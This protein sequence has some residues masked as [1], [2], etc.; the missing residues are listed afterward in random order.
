M[1]VQSVKANINGQNYNLTY[2][3]TSGKWE[4]TITAPSVTSWHE[5]NNKYGITVTA[6]DDAGN[7]TVKDRTDSTLG[8]ALQLRVLEKVKPTVSLTSPSSGARVITATPQIKFSLRDSD[9]GIKI[10]SLQL[11]I[12]GGSAIGHDASGMICT[13]VSGGYDCVYV[14]PTALSEGA[15]TITIQVSDNDGNTSDLLSSGFTVD[16]VPPALNITNPA[17]GLITNKS[18]LTVSGTTN[19]ETSSPVTITIKLNGVDQGAVTVTNGNFSKAITLTEG[20]NII[21]VKAVDSAGLS[22]TVTRTVKLDT[23]PPVITAVTVTPNPVDA[24]KTFVV[25]VTVSD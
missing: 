10:S 21:E 8:S 9:S 22:S 3:S 1:A 2:N 13:S 6:T 14:P 18:S 20:E 24:G 11:K 17:D 23:V 15:H 12:D 16:T 7:S 4:A 25:T 5:P 19:D